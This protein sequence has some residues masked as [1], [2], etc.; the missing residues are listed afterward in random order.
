MPQGSGSLHNAIVRVQL[1][2]KEADM[3]G[4]TYEHLASAASRPVR[5]MR[6]RT[7][8][9][10]AIVVG[11]GPAAVAILRFILPYLTVDD[12]AAMYAKVSADP[13][14]QSLVLWLS[15]AAVLTLVPAVMW[16]G[17][18][19]RPHVPRLTSA[20]MILLVPGYLCLGLLLSS[21]YLMFSG[22]KAGVHKTAIQQ[23]LATSH[24]TLLIAGGVF[25]LGHVLGTVLL[26]IAMLRSKMVPA[27]AAILTI[28]SQPLHFVAAVLVPSPPLDFAAWGMNAVGFIAAGGAIAR[29]TDDEWDVPAK[30]V[31]RS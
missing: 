4:A 17:R 30:P 16:V 5:D 20:A 22:A 11:I 12:P 1:L 13:G 18:L 26:G 24:P 10:A 9:F 2:E 19:V 29:L 25:V 31:Y 8:L 15:F 21:D 7:R 14:R 23:L 6:R 3:R 27:W 28:V